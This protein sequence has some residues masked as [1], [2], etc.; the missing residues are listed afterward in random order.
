MNWAPYLLFI[1]MSRPMEFCMRMVPPDDVGFTTEDPTGLTE[2]TTDP[3]TT[4]TV[5]EEPTTT[6]TPDDCTVCGIN[7]ILLPADD[8]MKK[9]PNEWLQTDSTSDGCVQ[10]NV[11][12]NTSPDCT[13]TILYADSPSG[14]TE[15]GDDLATSSEATLTCQKDG[16]WSSGTVTEIENLYC[17]FGGDCV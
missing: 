10:W 8:G 2:A 16:T 11:Y 14:T 7:D 12:C 6:A 17:V 5:T 9:R 15:I 1:L 3:M 4:V 13:S